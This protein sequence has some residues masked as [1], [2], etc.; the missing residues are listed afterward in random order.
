MAMNRAMWRLF[1]VGSAAA[2]VVIGCSSSDGNPAATSGND[3][4][5]DTKPE[6][7][8]DASVEAP[9][10]AI[11]MTDDA[12][13]DDDAST[14]AASD[15]G[16]DANALAPGEQFDPTA[17]APGSTCSVAYDV[18]VRR[19]GKCGQAQALCEPQTDGTLKL[20][21]YGRCSNEN[22][23]ANACLPNAQRHGGSCGLCGTTL[24]QCD[25]DLCTWNE[26]TCEN[27]VQ[28]GCS[29]GEVRY[30]SLSCTGGQTAKQTCGNACHWEAPAACAARAPEV[31][32]VPSVDG[33]VSSLE[34]KFWSDAPSQLAVAACP[35][36][37]TGAAGNQSY[38]KIHNPDTVPVKVDI[39]HSRS[40]IASSAII[41]TTLAVYAGATVPVQPAERQACV[42]A[43]ADSC[44]DS[45]CT[46]AGDKF[47]GLGDA[48]GV[49]IP[50]GGDIL[51]Y[52]GAKQSTLGDAPFVLNVRRTGSGVSS[53]STVAVPSV[54]QSFLSTFPLLASG[55]TMARA[56]DGNCPG[57]LDDDAYPYTLVTL[58][59]P[60]AAPVT[61][62]V[63][64]NAGPSDD[65][66][67]A[68]YAN[69]PTEATVLQCIG[70]VSDV[71]SIPGFVNDGCLPNLTI[72]A[73]GQAVL[74]VTS[75]SINASDL[76]FKLKVV[77]R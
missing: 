18:V 68:A 50:A 8:N 49:T 76:S 19:C 1:S 30:L 36:T 55:P 46:G 23:A 21:A 7:K 25:P 59:N 73:G 64:L 28:N 51:V 48:Q 57:F 38:T 67:I 75:Y 43:V 39:W 22:S 61:V 12:S 53:P 45:M 47:A 41:D 37:L 10:T 63:G 4:S 31:M 26:L 29:A 70:V 20:G 54:G 11:N 5:T 32:T 60:E 58:T 16:S 44:V 15:G 40:T 24:E 17:P 77:R 74:M 34:T 33:Y 65:L 6:Q 62:G 69:A 72:P 13:S 2:L 27:E 66:M 35:S 56:Y 14:D 52:S 3:A 71:C 9:D 42:G